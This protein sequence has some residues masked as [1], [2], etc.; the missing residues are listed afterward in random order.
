MSWFSEG[1]AKVG[2]SKNVQRAVTKP[3][4]AGAATLVGGPAAGAAVAKFLPVSSGSRPAAPVTVQEAVA[5]GP[6]PGEQSSVLAGFQA[7]L[8]SLKPTAPVVPEAKP[9]FWAKWGVP[10][11]MGGIALTAGGFIIYAMK[12][13]R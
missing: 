7:I 12:G 2:I 1:L 11:A 3:V 5:T 4:V 9:S 10:I 6:N 13:K 8:E